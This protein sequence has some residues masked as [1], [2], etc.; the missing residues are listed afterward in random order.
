MPAGFAPMVARVI[1]VLVTVGLGSGLQ[2]ASWPQA[3]L[4]AQQRDDD[5]QR[6]VRR[7]LAVAV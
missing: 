2:V 6:F 5:R 3:A 7:E 4:A 1:A